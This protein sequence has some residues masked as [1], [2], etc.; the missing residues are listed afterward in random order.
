[1]ETC[2]CTCKILFFVDTTSRPPTDLPMKPTPRF[3]L[4]TFAMFVDSF[5]YVHP[6]NSSL[7]SS[8]YALVPRTQHVIGQSGLV[9]RKDSGCFGK[10]GNDGIDGRTRC[11]DQATAGQQETN[12]GAHGNSCDI[13]RIGV[14][15]D[16]GENIVIEIE[17]EESLEH[18][19]I[20][21][22]IIFPDVPKYNPSNPFPT[23]T[24][25]RLSD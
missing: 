8:G 21:Y 24:D 23:L 4:Y 9:L 17:N 19:S 16:T 18:F 14:N 20:Q 7:H 5:S 12:E 1:M 2:V 3:T 10:A 22:T 13:V 25:H 15:T 6:P 11:I